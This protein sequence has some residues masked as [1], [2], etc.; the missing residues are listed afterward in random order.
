MV[1]SFPGEPQYGTKINKNTVPHNFT[2]RK[3]HT[4]VTCGTTSEHWEGNFLTQCPKYLLWIY[5]NR[6]LHY[7]E[8]PLNMTHS[9]RD[10][11]ELW[12]A[13]WAIEAKILCKKEKVN[14][15]ISKPPGISAYGDTHAFL[16]GICPKTP[17]PPFILILN[18]TVTLAWKYGPWIK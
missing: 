17:P 8:C 5:T 3:G 2:G 7:G 4:M 16:L 11:Y 10:L 6:V 1:H 18:P 13:Y 15:N 12:E 9:S 14:G